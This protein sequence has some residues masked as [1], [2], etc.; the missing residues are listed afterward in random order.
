LD[1]KF[2]TRIARGISYKAQRTIRSLQV[3]QVLL[4]GEVGEGRKEGNDVD[5]KGQD[6]RGIPSDCSVVVS[7]GRLQKTA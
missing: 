5:R 7:G 2:E 6:D 1:S 4:G 3:V